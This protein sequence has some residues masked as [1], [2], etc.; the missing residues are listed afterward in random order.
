MGRVLS[1]LTGIVFSL[2]SFMVVV[3]LEFPVNCL[4]CKKTKGWNLKVFVMCICVKLFETVFGASYPSFF[5]FRPVVHK[6]TNNRNAPKLAGEESYGNGYKSPNNGTFGGLLERPQID[7]RKRNIS[8][9]LFNPKY[10][11]K[12]VAAF[13]VKPKKAL[14]IEDYSGSVSDDTP[15]QY[16]PLK[17]TNTT[18]KQLYLQPTS[19][20]G[21]PYKRIKMEQ[22]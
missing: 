13:S 18:N 20:N 8:E 2:E 11:L 14:K 6:Q 22:L 3:R 5:V 7:S 17:L 21:P 19:F 16:V 1:P 12:K 15:V 10:P 4:M 9:Q